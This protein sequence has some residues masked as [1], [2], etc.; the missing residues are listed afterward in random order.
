MYRNLEQWGRGQREVFRQEIAELKAG[1]KYTDA[2]GRD[3]TL[4]RIAAL[5][6]RLA[7]INE[8]FDN[9]AWHE[10]QAREG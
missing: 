2:E 1:A 9:I 4:A 6:H 5:E 7:T 3:V 10:A 8:I